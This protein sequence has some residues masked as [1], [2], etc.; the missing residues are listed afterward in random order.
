MPR[1]PS[2]NGAGSRPRKDRAQRAQHDL[3]QATKA[4]EKAQAK[5]DKLQEGVEPAQAEVDR[6]Q[7]RVDYLSKNPDLPQAPET[8]VPDT[9]P[10]QGAPAD[11]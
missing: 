7:S 9:S 2:T 8:D 11:A 3:D 4:L 6:L 5:L 10:D 1:Q